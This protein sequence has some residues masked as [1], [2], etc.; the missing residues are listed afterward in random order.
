MIRVFNNVRCVETAAKTDLEEYETR[1]L[2]LGQIRAGP[3]PLPLSKKLGPIPFPDRSRATRPGQARHLQMRR[4]AIR[5]RSLNRTQC[6]L[7]NTWSYVRSLRA[8]LRLNAIVDR[9]F[10]LVPEYDM[11]YRRQ[12]V[13]EGGPKPLEAHRA[14]RSRP[15][16]A[17]GWRKL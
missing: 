10:P 5:M 13:T 6:G 7:V 15:R 12:A 3:L 9:P 4:P 14:M 1:R 2:G 8:P 17:T 11:N 16:S